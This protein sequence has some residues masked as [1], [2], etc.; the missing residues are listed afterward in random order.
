MFLALSL[1]L[2]VVVVNIAIAVLLTREATTAEFSNAY[3]ISAETYQSINND[4]YM[5]I[6]SDVQ[7]YNKK[8]AR[9]MHVAAKDVCRIEYAGNLQEDYSCKTKDERGA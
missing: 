2:L 4:R 1:L 3:I 9:V 5:E 8:A 6:H 7:S